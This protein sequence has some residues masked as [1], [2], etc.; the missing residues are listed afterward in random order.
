MSKFDFDRYRKKLNEDGE[1]APVSSGT[2][3]CPGGAYPAST[4]PSGSVGGV[5][6]PYQTL[7]NTV[8]IGNPI[9]A[10]RPGG[11]VGSGDRFDNTFKMATKRSGKVTKK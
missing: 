3:C 11:S 1:A 9:P 7:Y 5:Y 6:A 8:G 10:G 4:G 2:G